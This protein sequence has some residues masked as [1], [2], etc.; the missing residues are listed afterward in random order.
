MAEI[1]IK[2]R[3][4]PVWPWILGALVLMAVFGWLVFSITD[5]D[6][7]APDYTATTYTPDINLDRNETDNIGVDNTISNSGDAAAYVDFVEGMNG[8]EK[9]GI[10]H[11]FTS[12]GIRR[13]ADAL[14]SLAAKEGLE[15]A[16]IEQTKDQLYQAANQIQKDPQS[17]QHA[18]NIREAFTGA[19]DFMQT[20]QQKSYPNIADQITQVEKAAEAIDAKQLTTNQKE[21][22]KAFFEKSGDVVEEMAQR[23]TER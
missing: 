9:V 18:N 8:R 10:D 21:K 12:D 5:T 2:K 14:S 4:K 1:N 13:L 7:E 17:E 19:A 6:T 23:T 3:K 20:L 11:E 16:I 22:I 15:T